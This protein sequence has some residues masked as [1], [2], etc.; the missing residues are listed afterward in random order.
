MSMFRNL[1]VS[2][3]FALAFGLI[4]T[5]CALLGA[6]AFWGLSKMNDSSNRLA[7]I[8]L[9]S[10]QNL[11]QMESALQV[12]RR[13]DMGI[14]LCDTAD[15]I[16]YYLKNRQKASAKF[17]AAD[18]AYRRLETASQESALVEALS[19]EFTQYMQESDRTIV[20]LQ[21]GDKAQAS[22][23]TVGGNAP[24][25]RKADADLGRAI[26]INTHA[27]TQQCLN[28]TAV[29]QSVRSMALG[30]LVLTL[31][32]SSAIG[33]LLTRSIAPPLTAATGVLEALAAKD[34]TASPLSTDRTD[35]IGRMA[36]ALNTAVSTIRSLIGS[37][38]HG[39]ETVSSAAAELSATAGKSSEQAQLQ[40]SETSQIATA[41]QEM[42][43]TVAEVS[44]N[45]EQAN[46]ASREAAR[47]A[48]EGGAA[49]SRTAD[50]MQGISEFTNR[51][52][53]KMATLARRS[54]QIGEVVTTIREISE[55][56]NLLALNAAIEAQRAGEHGRGF[57]V[58]AGEVRRLA[59]RTKSAT[60]EITGTIV[61]I[62]SETREMLQ[63]MEQGKTG[64]VEGLAESRSARQTLEAIIDLAHRSEEQIAMIATASTEE[65]AASGEISRSLARICEISAL[66]STGAAETTQASL[67]LSRLAA[68]LDKEIKSFRLND[69]V[70]ERSSREQRFAAPVVRS[71]A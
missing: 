64:V 13:A 53:D 27:S 9:P 68:D 29:Y 71:A 69:D 26:E 16:G 10:A 33:W 19:T 49:I 51:T 67:D 24:I 41:T 66:T 44:K 17:E 36:T 48:N 57:A 52:V 56:T 1:P 25:F 40:C 55:Q 54:E 3:K 39:V 2:R 5:F 45:A 21:S 15:C 65:A 47:T 22:R 62:Q 31:L 60:E 34:L 59:E 11:A 14:M 42:A 70:M 8:A 46:L 4:C 50:R 7:Q 61:T 63:L 18:S 43:S 30:T 37:M 38:Q 35:E 20:L 12:L 6:I 28:A 23:Q 58:V 32:L